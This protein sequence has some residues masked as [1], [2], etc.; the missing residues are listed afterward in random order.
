MSSSK[1]KRDTMEY[2]KREDLLEYEPYEIKL[3]QYYIKND[4]LNTY[5]TK[6][7]AKE[8]YTEIFGSLDIKCPIFF[9]D[10]IS[11]KW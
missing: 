8:M 4:L 9:K 11:C 2:K 6:V 7:T 3:E 1:K 5:G 10:K